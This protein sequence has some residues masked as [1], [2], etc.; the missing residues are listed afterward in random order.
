M[1]LILIA[2]ALVLSSTS[3]VSGNET[4]SKAE[5]KKSVVEK[6]VLKT[7]KTQTFAKNDMR[8]VVVEPES[9]TEECKTTACWDSIIDSIPSS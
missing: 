5:N 4:N 3:V 6:L 9:Q 8:L 1:K 2:A 7:E